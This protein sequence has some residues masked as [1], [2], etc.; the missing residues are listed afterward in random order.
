[1]R[2]P[3]P[4]HTKVR[5]VERLHRLLILGL[6]AL[7]AVEL[8][9]ALFAH[10]WLNAALIAGILAVSASPAVLDRRLGVRIPAE[11][12]LL[13]VLFAFASLFLGEVHH[14]YERIWWWDLLLHSLS[15]V[16]MGILGFLLVNLLNEDDRI[17]VVLTPRFVALFAFLFAVGVGSL[18]EIFE[19]AMDRLAGTRMQKPMAS[20]PSGLTDTMW[21]LI[22]NALAALAVS[23][24]GW[25][26]LAG[27]RPTFIQRWIDKFIHDNPRLFRHARAVARRGRRALGRRR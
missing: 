18:W 5:A 15:G 19:F 2:P 21:D 27:G 13:A 22:A 1:M 11:F 20:D 16:L 14:Y 8:A 12:Q 24:L 3:A 26:Y 10:Q 23:L 17:E 4:N 6:G 9:A 25:R 7:L